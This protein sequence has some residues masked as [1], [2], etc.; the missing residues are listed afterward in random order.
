MIKLISMAAL[1]LLAAIV[2]AEDAA[3]PP[4][5]PTFTTYGTAQYRLRLRVFSNS[6]KDTMIIVKTDTVRSPKASQSEMDYMN[7]IAYFVGLKIKVNEKV[8]MQFQAGN[9]WVATEDVS[10]LGNNNWSAKSGLYP[11]FHLAFAKYDAGCVYVVAGKQQVNNNG[12]LD[13]IDRSLRSPKPTV[14]VNYAGAALVSW[15]VGTNGNM[16]GLK[17]GAPILKDN[18][19]LGAELFTS[20]IDAR[21]QTFVDLKTNLAKEEAYKNPS[22]TMLVLDV[23][24][25]I[26]KLTITPQIVGIINRI[27]NPRTGKGD[28]ETG[29][30][31]TAAY[32]I[33]DMVS[34]NAGGGV[35]MIS[36]EHSRAASLEP[37]TTTT[38]N[39]VSGVVGGAKTTYADTNYILFKQTGMI[40]GAGTVIKAGPGNV[41]FDLKYSSDKNSENAKMDGSFVFADLKYGWSVNKNF[42]LMPRVRL[43]QSTVNSMNA[44]NVYDPAVK[45]RRAVLESQTEIRPELIFT[46]SF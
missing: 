10:W 12:P 9:D 27:Y 8:S 16:M 39:L 33:N 28:H 40:V 35:A 36:N 34:V 1:L 24:M 20:V 14:G 29:G 22:S 2:F 17:V 23:P 46:G 15:V 25:S 13:L 26:D 42:I 7:Q 31:L 30:G 41:F 32:K 38:A 43:F 21:A 6:T 11:Y 44:V 45:T 4:A 19:K 18:F 5:G 37:T 3:T